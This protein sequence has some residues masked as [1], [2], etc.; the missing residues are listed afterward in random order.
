MN[1][2]QKVQF[3]TV[4]LCSQ[5]ETIPWKR[6]FVGSWTSHAPEDSNES[7]VASL[8]DDSIS[9]NQPDRNSQLVSVLK[10]T[11]KKVVMNL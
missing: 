2:C 8:S 4:V 9:T 1:V 11:A 7:R 3:Y 6:E 5:V 10:L